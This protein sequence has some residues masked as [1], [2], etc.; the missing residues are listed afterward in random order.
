[1]RFGWSA[2]PIRID[3]SGKIT[4]VNAPSLVRYAQ[5]CDKSRRWIRY[6]PFASTVDV[7]V[8]RNSGYA[9]SS[10]FDFRFWSNSTYLVP[11]M[12]EEC[13]SCRDL[14]WFGTALDQDQSVVWN[15]DGVWSLFVV[16]TA[17]NKIQQN[18]NAIQ[19]TRS[20]K[21]R[22][23]HKTSQLMRCCTGLWVS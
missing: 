19:V 7:F 1:M 2:S 12:L 6:V 22:Y 20:N 14:R 4:L 23:V 11:R 3:K 17:C 13:A 16:S 8:D 15:C 9:D 5:G 21:M 10:Y 18:L